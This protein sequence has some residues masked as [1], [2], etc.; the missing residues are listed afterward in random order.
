MIRRNR[1]KMQMLYVLSFVYGTC[2]TAMEQIETKKHGLEDTNQ[3]PCKKAK[4]SDYENYKLL[5]VDKMSNDILLGYKYLLGENGVTQNTKTALDLFLNASKQD[6]ILVQSFG[7]FLITQISFQKAKKVED[8]KQK[9]NL[10]NNIRKIVEKILEVP[11]ANLPSWF[12]LQVKLHAYDI[13]QEQN[14]NKK[15]LKLARELS[16]QNIDLNVQNKAKEFIEAQKVEC[17]LCRNDKKVVRKYFNLKQHLEQIHMLKISEID[18]DVITG[19][20]TV[21]YDSKT[22]KFIWK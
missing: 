22:K 4:N 17:K 15:L 20:K 5:T 8:K 1:T 3:M 10:M 2:V 6:N 16:S 7:K 11:D 21:I 12:L 14:N 18:C 9:K 13:Y 19:S